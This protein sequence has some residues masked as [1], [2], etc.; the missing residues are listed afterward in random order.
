MREGAGVGIW[1]QAEFLEVI[2]TNVLRVYLL[3]IH[4]YP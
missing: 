3:A 4:N 1:Q 2:G